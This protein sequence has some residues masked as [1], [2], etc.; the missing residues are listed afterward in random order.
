M[1]KLNFSEIENT[2]D[3]S[4]MKQIMAGSGQSCD[5]AICW[6]GN[7][8]A[9]LPVENCTGDPGTFCGAYGYS[10]GNWGYC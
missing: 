9:T 5:C 4:E 6:G 8:I 1:K 2:L 3:R 7:D 10:S